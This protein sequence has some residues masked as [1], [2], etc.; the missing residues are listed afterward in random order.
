[1]D[2]RHILVLLKVSA[3]PFAFPITKTSWLWKSSSPPWTTPFEHSMF[4]RFM[5]FDKHFFL[6]H[7]I[8]IIIV[9]VVWFVFV[10]ATCSSWLVLLLGNLLL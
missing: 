1:M 4:K 7:L 10:R 3:S 5:G 2:Q 8:I 9:I 6:F